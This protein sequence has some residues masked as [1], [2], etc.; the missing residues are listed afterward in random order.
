M[1]L[2]SHCAVSAH[3]TAVFDL[4][5]ARFLAKHML[6][7]GLGFWNFKFTSGTN[8]LGK[9]KCNRLPKPATGNDFQC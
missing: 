2:T 6:I 7:Y 3:H 5:D 8:L 4:Q 9:L 1:H